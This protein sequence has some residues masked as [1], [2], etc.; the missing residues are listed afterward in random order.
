MAVS[1]LRREYNLGNLD[2][3]TADADAVRQF[4]R[5]LDDALA[6]GV[7]EPHAMT[8]ATVTPGGRP[9][10]RIVLLRGF[11]AE[12]F[13]FYT[14]YDGRKGAELAAN[15]HAALV[16]YWADLERQVRVEG[17]VETVP[18]E[19]S[20]AYFQTRPRESQIGAWA[21]PQS[22]VIASREELDRRFEEFSRRFEGRPVPRPPRWGGYRVI[23]HVIE[24][25]QGRPGRLHDRLLYTHLG[26]EGWRR[27][28]LAP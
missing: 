4:A 21:S 11:S 15:P 3:T 16:L 8:L 23:P 27:E 26:E 12:G 18:P 10:A 25:W 22:Q 19:V 1:N 28:R 20:D 9:S 2:E 24:F 13:V 7:S 14:N 6:A 17:P 5:W